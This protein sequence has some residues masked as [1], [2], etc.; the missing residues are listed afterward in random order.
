M[1]PAAR[2]LDLLILLMLDSDLNSR[3]ALPNPTLSAAALL[4][5]LRAKSSPQSTSRL[6][7]GQGSKSAEQRQKPE[8]TSLGKS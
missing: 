2:S 8:L 4:C 3:V 5:E 1:L 6:G 7:E